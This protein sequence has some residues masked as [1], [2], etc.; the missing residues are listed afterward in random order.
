LKVVDEHWLPEEFEKKENFELPNYKYSN[1][2][3]VDCVELKDKSKI[4][5]GKPEFAVE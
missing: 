1:F 2:Y 4:I 5:E 3:F